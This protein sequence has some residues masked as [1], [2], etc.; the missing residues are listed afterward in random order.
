MSASGRKSSFWRG[1]AVFALVLG[2]GLAVPT[3]APATEHTGQAAV[4][5]I[6][7]SMDADD[8]AV[9]IRAIRAIK[10]GEW[11]KGRQAILATNDPLARKLFDWLAYTREYGT[12]EFSDVSAFVKAN[13]DWPRQGK[14]Q[15]T[16]EKAMPKSMNPA[17]VTAWFDVYPPQTADGID[18]YMK[19]LLAQNKTTAAQ[20]VMRGW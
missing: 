2:M 8:R 5:D 9:T 20:A 14:L 7:R 16:A 1:A 6:G 15:L 18:T 12:P 19:A 4:A 11:T 13:P 3:L 10:N 17:A